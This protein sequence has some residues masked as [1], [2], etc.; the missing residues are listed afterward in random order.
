MLALCHPRLT[1]ACRA[2]GVCVS[3]GKDVDD[4]LAL[5]YLGRLAQIGRIRLVGVITT[6]GRTA[7]RAE[8]ALELLDAV[9]R[10]GVNQ[11]ELAPPVQSRVSVVAGANEPLSAGAEGGSDWQ[12]APLVV[13]GEQRPDAGLR[14]ELSDP[15]EAARFILHACT[16]CHG[17]LRVLVL[18]PVTDLARAARL[19]AALLRSGIVSLHLQGQL[20]PGS[21]ASD[22]PLVPDPEAYNIRCD[23]AGATEALAAFDGGS[24]RF[25][26]VGKHAAYRTP[27]AAS[28]FRRW[29]GGAGHWLPRPKLLETA[30]TGIRQLARDAPATFERACGIAPDALPPSDSTDA[31]VDVLPHVSCPYDV[32]AA[33]TILPDVCDKFFDATYVLQEPGGRRV[34]LIGHADTENCNIRDPEAIRTHIVDTIGAALSRGYTGVPCEGDAPAQVD[35]PKE[36]RRAQSAS[37]L[38]S[39]ASLA[40]WEVRPRPRTSDSPGAALSDALPPAL[41]ICVGTANK[42]KLAAVKAACG[43][44]GINHVQVVGV[45]T[46]S[47]VP[48]QPI[49]GTESFGGALNRARQ[50]RAQQPDA[51]V[52]IGLENGLISQGAVVLGAR[53]RAPGGELCGLPP[54]ATPVWTDTATCAVLCKWS[55]DTPS[56]GV[57]H[58]PQVPFYGRSC[59]DDPAQREGGGDGDWLAQYVGYFFT[60]QKSFDTAMHHTQD[61]VSRDET[62]RAAVRC[63]LARFA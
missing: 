21:S 20:I 29:D 36:L 40:G 62:L 24:T 25:F 30:L 27:I 18:G 52:W 15:D 50:A 41:V 33:M 4:T 61:V 13:R 42:R 2:W 31:F 54:A 23:V 39:P 56:L 38:A 10:T 16:T 48:G 28:D 14:G 17:W 57:S 26:A 11:C 9:L 22:G 6:G 45:H 7:E 49:G 60:R 34:G 37:R 47:G 19:D 55:G 46:A 59:P 53:V 1:V 8:L 12:N 63:S 51:D 58:G 44:V 43:D 3:V 32:L 5:L 35:V